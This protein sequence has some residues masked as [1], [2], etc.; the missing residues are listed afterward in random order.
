MNGEIAF[1]T[2]EGELVAR[3]IKINDYQYWGGL[4]KEGVTASNI[5]RGAF[6]QS[7]YYETLPGLL[8]SIRSLVLNS[9]PGPWYE[10]LHQGTPYIRVTLTPEMRIKDL[11][12]AL[13]CTEDDIRA[14]FASTIY[15]T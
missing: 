8:R 13:E 12:E 1:S 9:K 3:F 14:H 2:S 15:I 4:C 10:L 5:L 11:A 7:H 6:M